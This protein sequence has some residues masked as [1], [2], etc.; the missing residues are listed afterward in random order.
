MSKRTFDLEFS[1]TATIE[2]DD[3]VIDAVVDDWRGA[4]YQLHSPEDNRNARVL[5][6]PEWEIEVREQ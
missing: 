4:F 1:G 5:R 2:L 3:A 6:G